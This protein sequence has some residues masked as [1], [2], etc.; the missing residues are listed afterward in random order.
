MLHIVHVSHASTLSSSDER[1]EVQESKQISSTC[2]AL[3]GG[4]ILL[5]WTHLGQ[6][7][8]RTLCTSK[9][10]TSPCQSPPSFYPIFIFFSGSQ[11]HQA[12]LENI[13]YQRASA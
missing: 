10:P 1:R 3:A 7:L 9:I 6:L 5:F 12:S 13:L 2:S 11:S 4:T 8:F